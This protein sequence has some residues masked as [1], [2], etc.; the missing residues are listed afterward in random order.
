MTKLKLPLKTVLFLLLLLVAQTAYGG[1]NSKLLKAAKVGDTVKVEQLL[2]KGASVHA[3]GALGATALLFAAGGGH[4]ETVKVLMDAGADVPA[5]DKNGM[6]AL[7]L[8][9]TGG[10][11]EA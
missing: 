5:K 6:T 9:A 7:M 11:T 8:T 2:E 4:T 3:K 10:H 1:I